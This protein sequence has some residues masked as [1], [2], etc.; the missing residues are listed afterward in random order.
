VRVRVWILIF[1]VLGRRSPSWQAKKA[2]HAKQ[3]KV[4]LAALVIFLAHLADLANYLVTNEGLTFAHK[5]LN[6]HLYISFYEHERDIFMVGLSFIHKDFAF[7]FPKP[8]R[9]WTNFQTSLIEVAHLC[10]FLLLIGHLLNGHVNLA[11]K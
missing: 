10:R 2:P 8:L 3:M 1:K 7:F 9:K 11:A 5:E 4:Y 6:G